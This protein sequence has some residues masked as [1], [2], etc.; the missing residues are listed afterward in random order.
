[1]LFVTH[2]SS[3]RLNWNICIVVV[4]IYDEVD[5]KP[6]Q[7][8]FGTY[9]K[10]WCRKLQDPSNTVGIV[11][12]PSF[13]FHQLLLWQDLTSGRAKGSTYLHNLYAEKS[14]LG[15]VLG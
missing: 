8:L 7:S 4:F 3:V 6:A 2:V 1:M 5:R 13:K 9:S 14:L 10:Y 15:K 12:T 11:Q